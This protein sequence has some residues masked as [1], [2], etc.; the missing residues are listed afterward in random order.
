[1]SGKV[2]EIMATWPP[3][4][5]IISR[6]RPWIR[7]RGGPFDSPRRGGCLHK[8][9]AYAALRVAELRAEDCTA[10]CKVW[11]SHGI[12]WH[13][14]SRQ[15]ATPGAGSATPGAGSATPG[16]GSATPGRS[17]ATP[18]WSALRKSVYVNVLMVSVIVRWSKGHSSRAWR[19]FYQA[20]CCLHQ[21]WRCLRRAWR[22]AC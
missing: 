11:A 20:W 5:N 4:S 3:V 21:A 6:L 19:C 7:P 22:S 10:P 17:S 13:S 12:T 16:A 18:G 9:P 8:S 14:L 2:P 15:S 1:M